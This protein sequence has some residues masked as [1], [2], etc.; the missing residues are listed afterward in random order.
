MFALICVVLVLLSGVHCNIIA[1]TVLFTYQS[2]GILYTVW[3][4]L[5]TLCLAPLVAHVIGGVSTT[6]IIGDDSKAPNWLALL[7]HYNPI[8]I[9]WRYSVIADRRLRACNWDKLDMAA[10]NAVFWDADRGRWD[11]SEDIMIRSRE[12]I[13][14]L[15]E[16][17]HVSIISTSIFKTIVLSFQGSQAIFIIFARLAAL[18]DKAATKYNFAQGLPVVFVPLGVMALMRLPAALWLSD[19]YAYLHTVAEANNCG[20]L[21]NKRGRERCVDESYL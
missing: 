19:D 3:F 20:R 12:W 10:C 18:T 13:T 6:T 11:G 21:G 8:S 14:K 17:S 15:P 4:N 9:A 2:Q 5:F 7:P 1:P 16:K